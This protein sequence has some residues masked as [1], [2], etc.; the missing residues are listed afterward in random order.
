M[1]SL[2]YRHQRNV[3][4]MLSI[5]FFTYHYLGVLVI[6]GNLWLNSSQ[7]YS[8][9]IKYI[10]ITC[11]FSF[12][13]HTSF[14]TA[15]CNQPLLPILGRWC[16]KIHVLLARYN[17]IQACVVD[18]IHWKCLHN[19]KTTISCFLQERVPVLYFPTTNRFV[20]EVGLHFINL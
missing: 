13:L 5:L 6:I 3:K 11:W 2:K 18:V 1:L 20:T 10:A 14:G 7:G 19:S 16:P 17:Q 15:K 12:R 8:V 9:R 4:W